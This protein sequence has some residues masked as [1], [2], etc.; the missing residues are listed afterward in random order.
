MT[1]WVFLRGLSREARHWGDFPQRFRAVLGESAGDILTPDLPGNGRLFDEPSPTRVDAMLEAC[2]LELHARGHAPPYHL[3]A[4]SLGGM[5][6]AAWA[7]RYP[8]ECRA[9]VLISTSLRPY[10]PV[11]QRLRPA[12]WLTLVRLMLLDGETRERAILELTSARADTLRTLMP[13]WAAYAREYPPTRLNVLRQLIAAARFS[14]A[15]KP[16]VPVL[17]LAARHDRMVHPDCSR[18]LAEAWGAGLVLHPDAGHDLPLDDGDWVAR[19]VA[20]WLAEIGLAD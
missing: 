12:A 14:A 16:A 1:T 8:A 11:F 5:V 2:R 17:L 9:A 18:R 6:A 3:L 13:T 7:K 10:C 19:E 15:E 4:L 20:A